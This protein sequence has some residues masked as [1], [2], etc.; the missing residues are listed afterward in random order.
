[1]HIGL[2]VHYVLIDTFLFWC[3]FF[4]TV[5]RAFVVRGLSL[6]RSFVMRRQK[7]SRKSSRRAFRNGVQRQHPKNRLN[8][9]FMRGGIRL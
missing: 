4:G 8:G 2:L 3:H 9:F 1:M 6:L 5:S 7:M